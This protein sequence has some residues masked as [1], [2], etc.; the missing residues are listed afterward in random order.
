MKTLLRVSIFLPLLIAIATA[1]TRFPGADWKDAT[2][3][4]A[5]PFA[6]RGGNMSLFVGQ[7]PDSLNYYLANNTFCA[8]LFGLMYDTLLE[9]DPVTLAYQPALAASWTLSDDKTVFT[10]TIDPDARWSDGKPITAADVQWTYDAIMDPANR[11]GP[12]KV[13][14]SRFERPEIVDTR[15]IRFKAQEVHWENL[16]AAGGFHIL[17]RH[18][19]H[20]M[21]FNTINTDFPVQS[22]PYRIE[23]LEEGELAVLERRDDWWRDD[24]ERVQY[25]H[26]FDVLTFRFLADRSNAFELFKK[27]EFDLYP[28]HTSRLWVRET[29]GQ[30]FEKNWIV[31]QKIKN[32]S[33]IG[34]QGFA[35]NMRRP[36]FQDPRV[37]QALAHLLDRGKLNRTIM[38]NQYFLHRSYFED[39]Y[40]PGH[41]CRNPVYDFDPEKAVSLLQ[42]AG[43]KANPATGKL[44]KDGNPFVLTFLTRSSSADQFLQVYSEDL[45]DA[46]I[47]ITIDRKDWAAW[48]KD[49]RAYNFDMTWAAWS[50]GVFRNPES[51]WHSDQADREDGNNITGFRDDRVDALIEQQKTIFDIQVRNDLLR[52]LDGIVTRA[53][54]YILLWNIDATRLLYW[55][56]FGTP[57]TVLSRFGDQDSALAYWWFDPDA[58]AELED[59]RSLG[60][61]LPPQPPVI[62]FDAAFDATGKDN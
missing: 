50:A 6:E 29:Q 58:A 47:T 61:A 5:S 62:E 40:G 4:L 55:N 43:W 18:A 20:D 31:R 60:E 32:D 45:K 1:E 44:E 26:N 9:L 56:R 3:P 53:C 16:M 54:P 13:S 11:T 30:A 33:P 35:M 22:G 7:Y 2:N 49:M 38:Y 19:F 25:T 28:V 59:A 52:E 14:L 37:R 36:L 48:S 41:P 39:L 12:H 21:D 42:E 17:P 34:F 24:Q 15:T 23:R 10:F 8:T 51:M 57:D 46:G 27:G